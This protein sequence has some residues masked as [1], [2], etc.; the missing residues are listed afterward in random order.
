MPGRA[1][2]SID[3]VLGPLWQQTGAQLVAHLDAQAFETWI[4]PSRLLAVEADTAVL[5]TPNVFVRDMIATHYRTAV[6]AALRIVFGRPLV[7][8]L[9]IGTSIGLP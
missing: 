4:A 7:L 8:E 1:S 6:E 3:A 2:E 5:G 9:V